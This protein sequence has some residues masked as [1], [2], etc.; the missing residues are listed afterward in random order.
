MTARIWS[1]SCQFKSGGKCGPKKQ[2]SISL[3]TNACSYHTLVPSQHLLQIL[4]ILSHHTLCRC[5]SQCIPQVSVQ[6]LLSLLLGVRHFICRL[7]NT[8][9]DL[10][11][12][13]LECECMVQLAWIIWLQYE[14]TKYSCIQLCARLCACSE[15]S[16]ES[17]LVQALQKSFGWDYKL[18][19]PV[20]ICM[21]KDHVLTL[22]IL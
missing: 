9:M 4:G 16:P 6:H 1:W 19:C 14:T 8:L 3:S 13:Q 10:K 18:R 7:L 12:V 15:I 2:F 20:C 5:I 17:S 22:K 21:Q 11:Y